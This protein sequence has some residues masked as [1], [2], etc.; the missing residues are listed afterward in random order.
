MIEINLSLKECHVAAR[1]RGAVT[2]AEFADLA[3]TINNLGTTYSV[4]IY[5]DW[6]SVDHWMFA[7][8]NANG[9]TAWRRAAR[10]IARAAI[11]HDHRLNRQ[12]A[13]LAAILRKEGVT[14]RSWRPQS[15]TAA[16]KWLGTDSWQP[17]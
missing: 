17:H 2:N 9:V 5:L 6:V 14:V 1:F 8:A 10:M 11:I 16:A 15:A 3:A 13:W 7:P 4:L 12:A